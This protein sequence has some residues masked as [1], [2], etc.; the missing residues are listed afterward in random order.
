MLKS[1]QTIMYLS[2]ILCAFNNGNVVY[3]N[4]LGQ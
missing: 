4:I 3:K 1:T 2:A